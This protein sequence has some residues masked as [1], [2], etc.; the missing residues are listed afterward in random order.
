[1]EIVSSGQSAAEEI[2]AR[3]K[4]KAAAIAESENKRAAKKAEEEKRAVLI[5]AR[6][7]AKR[8]VLEEKRKM[9]DMLLSGVPEKERERKE[10]ELARVLYE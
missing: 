3:A 7:E 9:L 10:I 5:P 6:L 2:I 4:E 1:M 8:M